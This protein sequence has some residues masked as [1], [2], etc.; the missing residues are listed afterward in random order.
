MKINLLRYIKISDVELDGEL[1]SFQLHFEKIDSR[2]VGYKGVPAVL[3]TEDI[4]TLPVF[5]YLGVDITRFFN[6]LK[7]IVTAHEI[8]LGE[9]LNSPVN[10]THEDAE[11]YLNDEEL[12]NLLHKSLHNQVFEDYCSKLK[13]THNMSIRIEF[14]DQ[15]GTERLYEVVYNKRGIVQEKNESATRILQPSTYNIYESKLRGVH[16]YFIRTCVYTLDLADSQQ[17]HNSIDSAIKAIN[18][19]LNDDGSGSRFNS[20]GYSTLSDNQD[21]KYFLLN[22]YEELGYQVED[23]NGYE[24]DWGKNNLRDASAFRTN[25]FTEPDEVKFIYAMSYYLYPLFIRG[26]VLV[27]DNSTLLDKDTLIQ[28]ADIVDGGYSNRSKMQIVLGTP[29]QCLPAKYMKSSCERW[30]NPMTVY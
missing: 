9:D 17:V 10:I 25:V 16:V 23:I 30:Y 6:I 11:S 29:Q 22:L 24:L 26:G 1:Y 20:S 2:Y 28:L 21:Y 7:A 5:N 19:E 12:N 18:Y 14:F 3:A 8:K 13:Y 27:L 15:S 4:V